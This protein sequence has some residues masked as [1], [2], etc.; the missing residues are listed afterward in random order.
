MKKIGKIIFW[1]VWIGIL[2][3]LH[4]GIAAGSEY[5]DSSTKT[6]G[7]VGIVIWWVLTIGITAIVWKF[8]DKK[9]DKKEREYKEKYIETVEYN[10]ERYG[11]I[12]FKHNLEKHILSADIKNVSFTE[13]KLEASILNIDDKTD[14][15]TVFDNLKKYSDNS[16][17]IKERNY[18]ELITT[19]KTVDNYDKDG[20]LFEVSEQFL[21]D[22]FEFS[23][24]VIQDSKTISLWG[25]WESP[26]EQDYSINY[27]CNDDTIEVES[28]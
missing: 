17:S 16:K 23:T 1:I 19:L 8:Q 14:L 24:I 11:K 25:S 21:R 10:D 13:K 15:K 18:P 3:F 26:Y 6:V 7:I 20:N 22:N 2:I 4:M 27:N 28:L 12:I 5:N 9:K